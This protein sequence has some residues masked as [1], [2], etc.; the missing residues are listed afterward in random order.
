MP[1]EDRNRLKKCLETFRHE[2]AQMNSWGEGGG[3]WLKF[4]GCQGSNSRAQRSL[5]PCWCHCRKRTL[6]PTDLF[7]ELLWYFLCPF[8]MYLDSSKPSLCFHC[9]QFL[10]YFLDYQNILLSQTLTH[11]LYPLQIILHMAAK[12]ISH[13]WH[14]DRDTQWLNL[15]VALQGSSQNKS[16]TL[17]VEGL[18]QPELDLPVWSDLMPCLCLLVTHVPLLDLAFLFIFVSFSPSQ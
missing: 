8:L 7:C 2:R 12:I 14:W 11:S 10:V 15:A 3:K 18:P 16:S 4:S 6:L 17:A 1:A 13:T 9:I 5:P